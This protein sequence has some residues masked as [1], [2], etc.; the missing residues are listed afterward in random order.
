[1]AI[2]YDLCDLD[3]NR[4]PH[5]ERKQV[6]KLINRGLAKVIKEFDSGRILVKLSVETPPWLHPKNPVH[7][8]AQRGGSTPIF[9]HFSALWCPCASRG[10]AGRSQVRLPDDSRTDATFLHNCAL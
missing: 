5:C 8:P 10:G 6:R 4:L 9:T 7:R 2:Y 3:G 1:M